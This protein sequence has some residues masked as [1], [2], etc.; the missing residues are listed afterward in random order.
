MAD[1]DCFGNMFPPKEFEEHPYLL[2]IEPFCIK[3]N[4]YYAG[5]AQYSSLLM[6]TGEGLIVLDTPP[7][8][9]LPGFINNVWKLGF[10]LSDIK[11]IL[12]SHGHVDHYGSANQLRAMTE[13]T[14]YLSRADAE[15]FKAH[16]QF[17]TDMEALFS[18]INERVVPD[19]LIDDGDVISLGNT[20]V[21]CVT[22]PGHSRGTI[23]NFWTVF[24]G[25]NSYKAGV[26]GG[27]GFI[28]LSD[29][30]LEADGLEKTQREVFMHSIEKVWDEPVDIMLGNHPFHADTLRKR[31]KQIAG[32][33]DAFVD[34]TEWQRY[35][36]KLK[37]SYKTYLAMTPEEVADA[38]KESS[39]QKF[40]GQFMEAVN[41]KA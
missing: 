31:A 5:N 22:V 21:R 19:K 33:K 17:Y 9:N 35:L 11:I 12:L 26:Y 23:A 10:K 24:D 18:P 29:E 37:Q 1:F 16:P 2:D 38:Y 14:V 6:D 40:T 15:D 27:A 39:F 32:D 13:A 8:E 41:G 20:D 36:Q 34:P 3:G 4:L 7:A 30:M 25:E 28:T